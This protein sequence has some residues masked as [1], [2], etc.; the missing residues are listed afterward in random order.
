MIPSYCL[1]LA[2]AACSFLFYSCSD[3]I[4][5][6]HVP[7]PEAFQAENTGEENPFLVKKYASVQQLINDWRSMSSKLNEDAK[8]NKSAAISRIEKER[9][10]ITQRNAALFSLMLTLPKGPEAFEG[11]VFLIYTHNGYDV[12]FTRI[13]SL[14]NTFPDSL[15]KT[16]R[17]KPMRKKLNEIMA[18]D[19]RTS[20]DLSAL[21]IPVKDT[22]GNTHYLN[23]LNS[24]YILIDFWASWCTPCR[25]ENR[26]MVDEISEIERRGFVSVV[27]F[28]LDDQPSGWKQATAIDKLSFLSLSDSKGFNSPVAAAF[29]LR[30]DNGGIPYNVLIDRQGKIL[31]SNLWGKKLH[32]VI[33]SLPKQ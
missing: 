12:P 10:L 13:D 20:Y 1:S 3:G 8:R 26:K 7:S 30:R 23:E 31:A 17:T 14:Y 5:Q 32:E 11:F 25:V 6:V 22:S 27:A 2:I 21:N 4:S 18:R 15:T 33:A 29:G 9:Q 28:S 16:A 19:E 24:K